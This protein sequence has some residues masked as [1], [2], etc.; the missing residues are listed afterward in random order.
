MK[1]L[2][3]DTVLLTK[4]SEKPCLR[5]C[6]ESLKQMAVNRL[7]V[8]NAGSTDKTLEI[9]RAYYPDALILFDS[10]TR[11]T[12]RQLGIQQVETEWLLFLDSEVMICLKWFEKTRKYLADPSVGAV[13]GID[14]PEYTKALLTSME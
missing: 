1:Q 13:H 10:G 14:Y 3:V 6:L 2:K 9:I 11:A 5:E 8:I 4:N 12:A 7:I